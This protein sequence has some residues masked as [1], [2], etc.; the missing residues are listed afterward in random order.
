MTELT[1]FEAMEELGA[2]TADMVA[3]SVV[4]DCGPGVPLA[5]MRQFQDE[6][7]ETVK[8]ANLPMRPT[9]V[10]TLY[11]DGQCARKYA[12]PAGQWAVTKTHKKKHFIM[13]LGDCT[14]WTDG[15][16]KRLTG[17]HF[18]ITHPG[19]KRII[20]AHADTLFITTHVTDLTDPDAIEAE[21]TIP[22]EDIFEEHQ[23]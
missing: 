2:V 7:A 16:Q 4:H 23:P 1:L 13:V 10:E 21:L 22:E 18:F 3:R 8:A 6:I 14:I 17:F 19:T 15:A 5:F 9:Q 12:M 11:A 20:T